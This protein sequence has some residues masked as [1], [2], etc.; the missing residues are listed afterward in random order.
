MYAPF[1]SVVLRRLDCASILVIVLISLFKGYVPVSS[2]TYT[3]PG[4]I[5][6]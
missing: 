5:N 6:V 1:G 2:V 3:N 4:L